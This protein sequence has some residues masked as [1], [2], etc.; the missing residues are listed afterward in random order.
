MKH[1]RRSVLRKWFTAKSTRDET[2]MSSFWT[3]ESFSMKFMTFPKNY[4]KLFQCKSF[5]RETG[6]DEV[7][8]LPHNVEIWKTSQSENSDY[9]WLETFYGI[10]ILSVYGSPGSMKT[11]RGPVTSKW[12]HNDAIIT[13]IYFWNFATMTSY[14]A[15]VIKYKSDFHVK[16]CK[17][18]LC[19]IV[20]SVKSF[21]WG[22]KIL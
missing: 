1:L 2:Y 12:C 19:T 6:I 15:D 21:K 11:V 17:T 4:L 16:S 5:L 13:I 20:P 7:I 8:I 9:V 14:I 22:T 10:D 18:C 3:A